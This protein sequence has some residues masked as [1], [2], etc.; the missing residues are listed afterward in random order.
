MIFEAKTLEEAY[1]QASAHFNK[2]ISK[3]DIEVLQTPTKGILGLFAKNAVIEVKDA[4]KDDFVIELPIQEVAKIAKKE[5]NELFALSCFNIDE[6]DVRVYDDETLLFEINGDDAALLIG[7]EGYRYNALA[8]MIFTWIS[9]KYGYRTRLEI[10]SFLQNQYNMM[11]K[12]LEPIIEE[13]KQKGKYKTKPFDGILVYIALEI[14]RKQF[15]NK[16]IAIKKNRDNEQY[17]I[18]NEFLTKND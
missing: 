13:I 2:S 17:I 15:P 3:L 16:Y 6:I 10:A 4:K 12:F 9:Q 18:V 14:L 5:I 8:N 11:Q 7:K 1:Q